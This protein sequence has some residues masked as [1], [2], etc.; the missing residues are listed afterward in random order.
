MRVTMVPESGTGRI[1]NRGGRRGRKGRAEDSLGDHS[2]PVRLP[3]WRRRDAPGRRRDSLPCLHRGR[4]I[5]RREQA[6]GARSPLPPPRQPGVHPL[7]CIQAQ[8]QLAGADRA[9]GAEAHFSDPACGSARTSTRRRATTSAV[10]RVRS[11]QLSPTTV[12]PRPPRFPGRG[13]EG[14]C[15]L[16]L[17]I[18]VVAEPSGD[19]RDTSRIAQWMS[20]MPGCLLFRAS[21]VHEA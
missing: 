7:R 4:A 12:K 16:N 21:L 5:A 20:F 11:C 9:T 3:R 19:R 17:A 15:R 2:V 13:P 8:E 14:N 6:P 10:T 1:R 18:F